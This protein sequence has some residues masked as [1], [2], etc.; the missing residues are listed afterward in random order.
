M[1]A[2]R[3]N[4]LQASAGALPDWLRALDAA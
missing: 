4:A 1:A 3:A 2:A